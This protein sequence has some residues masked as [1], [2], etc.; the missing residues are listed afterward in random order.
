MPPRLGF[1][2][3]DEKAAD[4]S[5]ND[6]APWRQWYKTARWQRLRMQCF[7]RD[8]FTCQRTGKVLAGKYPAPDS[9]V[10]NHKHPHK[11]NPALFWDINNLETVS[12]A[13]HDQLIQAEE[14]ANDR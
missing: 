11:G 5:R 10:A 9:P 8:N 2:P 3:G 6:A 1:M 13:V 7:V 14:R 12:K 4:K